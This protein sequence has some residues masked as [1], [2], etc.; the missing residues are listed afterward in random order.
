MIAIPCG[1]L[2]GVRLTWQSA[3]QVKILRGSIF[4]MSRVLRLTLSD[5]QSPTHFCR[6]FD[7]DSISATKDCDYQCGMWQSVLLDV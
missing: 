3:E 5:S 2:A 4:A 1:L 7:G 6:L